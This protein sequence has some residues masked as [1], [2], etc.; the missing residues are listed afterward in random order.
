[1]DETTSLPVPTLDQDSCYITKLLALADRY[2]FPDK[3]DFIDLLT[4]QR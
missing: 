1:M 4:M 3:K 2:A